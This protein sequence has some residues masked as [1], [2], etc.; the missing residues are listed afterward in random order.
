M[1]GR[2]IWDDE[3]SP[4]RGRTYSGKVDQVVPKGAEMPERL[5]VLCDGT[6]DDFEKHEDGSARTTLDRS[7]KRTGSANNVLKAMR[8]ACI[9]QWA[10][11]QELKRIVTLLDGTVRRLEREIHD[12]QST[13][14]V[15]GGSA[16]LNELGGRVCKIEKKVKRQDVIQAIVVERVKRMYG[17]RG[18][19]P[20]HKGSKHVLAEELQENIADL[21]ERVRVIEG[22]VGV[23]D[24][25]EEG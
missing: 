17:E 16:E 14:R 21:L 1:E 8:E 12:L 9:G 22:E 20:S 18:E 24:A 11:N 5:R 3:P 19:R 25:V 6:Y 23:H 13:E 10:E 4:W 2:I 7:D 15:A